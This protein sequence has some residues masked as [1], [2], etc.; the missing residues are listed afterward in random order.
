M[1]WSSSRWQRIILNIAYQFNVY[2]CLCVY[3]YMCV[4]VSHHVLLSYCLQVFLQMEGTYFD[5]EEK[6]KQTEDGV[7]LFCFCFFNL[8]IQSDNAGQ[9]YN[10]KKQNLN[11]LSLATD[12]L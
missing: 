10:N 1:I 5:F 2:V 4:R 11:T 9:K 12:L 3:I 7:V 8:T 6:N